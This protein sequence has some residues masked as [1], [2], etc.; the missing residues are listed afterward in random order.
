MADDSQVS[1]QPAQP[2]EAKT[3]ASELDY[4]TRREIGREAVW[5]LSSAKPGNGVDQLR[6]D[7]TDTYWQSDG[8]QPHL[9]NIQFHKK[10]T[11]VEIAFHLDFS[12]DESY[13]PK[14]LSIRAGSSFHDLVEVT[15]KELHEPV[16]WVR[17]PLFAPGGGGAAAIAADAAGGAEGPVLRAHFVQ[18]CV[19]AM[20]QNGRDTH[21]RQVKVFGPRLASVQHDPSLLEFISPEFETF[22]CIR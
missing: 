2:P 5:S 17:V 19:V 15:I 20:H 22:A 21:I 13:T 10:M 7:S 3:E 6:D 11:V 1:Q 12:S 14:K 18:I 9:I 8:G 16:G 4:V